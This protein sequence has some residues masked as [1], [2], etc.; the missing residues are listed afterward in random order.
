MKK[1]IWSMI[2]CICLCFTMCMPAFAAETPTIVPSFQ[3]NRDLGSVSEQD[4]DAIVSDDQQITS[5]PNSINYTRGNTHLFTM[6]T[7][8]QGFQDM[9]PS[10]LIDKNK[11]FTQDDITKGSLKISG[12]MGSTDARCN[13]VEVGYALYNATSDTYKSVG[14]AFFNNNEYDAAYFTLFDQNVKYYGYAEKA[15]AGNYYITGE[16]DFWDSD[17][18]N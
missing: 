11:Y 17:E 16:L 14:Y 18:Y 6:K 5:V 3:G 1:N 2:V 9:I 8:S 7:S 10:D 13:H 12:H 15:G 4:R